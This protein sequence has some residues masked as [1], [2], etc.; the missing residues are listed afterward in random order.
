MREERQM[1]TIIYK[2]DNG[3]YSERYFWTKK[4]AKEYASTI[5]NAKIT[6]EVEK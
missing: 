2:V 4:E 6:A 1:K 5:P 3:I